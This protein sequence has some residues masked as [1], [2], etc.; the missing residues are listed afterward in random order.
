MAAGNANPKELA[1]F[2]RRCRA[3]VVK[4]AVLWSGPQGTPLS[5][6]GTP[7]T[8]AQAD[9]AW[10]QNGAPGRIRTFAHGFRKPMLYPLSYGGVARTILARDN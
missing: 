1:G 5:G 3:K 4:D 10:T 8:V 9:G 2:R 6:G 7:S